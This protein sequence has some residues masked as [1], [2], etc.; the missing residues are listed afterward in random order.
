MLTVLSSSHRV[1]PS[2]VPH[3][4]KAGNVNH[5]LFQGNTSGEFLLLLDCDMLAEPH[6]LQVR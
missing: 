2:G 5:A 3:H 4:A 6:I 1:K